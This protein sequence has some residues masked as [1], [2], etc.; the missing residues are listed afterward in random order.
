MDSASPPATYLH[1]YTTTEQERLRR[2]ARITEALIYRDIDFMDHTHIL[3]VGCGVGA[4][5]EILLRRF[6]DIRVTGIDLHP[7][8][9]AAARTGLESRPWCPGRY[10][11][12]EAD[13]TNTPFTAGQF[14]G[15]FLCWVLEHIPQ[16]QR[17]LA[18]VK[19]VLAPRS[20]A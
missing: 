2:Q 4:Q 20:P 1:G 16:P 13:A 14:D 19:R 18:E 6:P 10:T 17:V 15:A 8:Q 5:T 12:L 11:L 7:E 3:E 9:L